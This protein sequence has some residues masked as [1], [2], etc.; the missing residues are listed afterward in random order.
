[1]RQKELKY[2]G[3]PQQGRLNADDSPFA[4][5]PNE[6][7]NAENVR[8]GSTDK[9][10]TGVVESVGGNVPLTFGYVNIGGQKWMT[11]NLNVAHF[12]NGDEIP[13][14][15]DPVEWAA[16][17]YAACCFYDNDPRNQNEY[18]KLYNW[19][20]VNDPR[21][22]APDGW[23]VPSQLDFNYLINTLGTDAG[24][25][26]KTTGFEF[27][28]DPN[29]GA[30]NQSQLSM[31]GHGYRDFDGTYAGLG[32]YGDFWT[33][34]EDSSTDAFECYLT[35]DS[36]DFD[37]SGSYTKTAGF[38]VRLIYDSNRYITIGAV[39]D[40]ENER[41][42]YF[43]YDTDPER[44]DQVMC[45][46]TN[47][48]TIYKIID[49]S[50]VV[51]GLN[52]SKNSL[53]HSARITDDL[54]S[55][56]DGTNNEPR[57]LNI[58]S[59][60][61]GNNSLFETDARPYIF[62][63]NF[64]EITMIKP[65]PIYCPNIQKLVDP[66]YINNFIATRSFEFAFM[67]QYYDNEKSVVGSY[68]IAS[69]LDIQDGASNYIQVDMDGNENIPYTVRK[70]FLIVRVTDG[71][72]GGGNTAFV[73]RTWDREIIEDSLAIDDQNN[74]ISVLTN[75]FYNEIVGE[76]LAP[77]DV[78]R[79]YDLVPI[80]SQTHEI[81]KQR[82]FLGNNINGYDT[83]T[84]TSLSVEANNN[85]TNAS[86]QSFQLYKLTIQST[87]NIAA[88]KQWAFKGYLIFDGM[89]YWLFKTAGSYAYTLG[90]NTLPADPTQPPS[91][92]VINAVGNL[93]ELGYTLFTIVNKL[94]PRVTNNTVPL[95][96]PVTEDGTSYTITRT[97]ALVQ[98][99]AFVIIN[100]LLTSGYNV[101]AQ[102]S[103]YKF[104]VVFYDY[105]MRK[106]GVIGNVK[107]D[108]LNQVYEYTSVTGEPSLISSISPD[109]IY[110]PLANLNIVQA[111]DTLVISDAD[112]SLD[113]TY[114]V[115][116]VLSG[117]TGFRVT[118]SVPTISTAIS[119]VT[120][121]VYRQLRV[122]ITTPTAQNNFG[123][124]NNIRWQLSNFNRTLEIPDWAYYYSVV[125]TLNL[126]TR[127]F[128][129]SYTSAARYFTKDILG[130]WNETN[131]VPGIAPQGA[132]AIG[133]PIDNL[134]RNGLG[135]TYEPE[136]EDICILSTNSINGPTT[137][138]LP[139]VG[140]I[141]NYILV[142]FLDLGDS[143]SGVGSGI[144]GMNIRY[145]V[146]HPYK[147]VEQEPYY[148]V[149]EIY[150]INNPKTIDRE[151]STLSG[152]L[153]GDCA[154]ITRYIASGAGTFNTTFTAVGM[155]A[156]D[157]YYQRWDNDGGKI[158]VITN[159]G[160]TL[161]PTAVS[162][163]DAIISGSSINGTSTFRANDVNYVPSDCGSITKLQL[164]SKIQNEGT[165]ML[166]LC[167]SEI[168][169]MYLGEQQIIDS[170]GGT[171]F[172]GAS[173]NV[174]STINTLKGNYGCINP[175]SVVQY[176]GR[177][178]FFDASN[179]RVLQYSENGIDP[180]S[181]I[182]M[183]RFW[184]NWAA[185]YL[186]M[187]IE[188][189][190][191]YGDRPY[192]FAIVDPFHDEL[193]M[194]IPTLTDESPKGYLPDYPNTIYPF[195]ILDYQGK[196]I[197]YN[198]GLMANINPHWQGS[199]MFNTDY[200]GSVQNKVLSFRH[201]LPYLH[202]Q[203]NQNTFYDTYSP[204]KIMFTSNSIPQVPKV[205]D[206]FLSESN[207]IPNFVYFYNNNPFL[208]TSDLGEI[209]F[210]NVEGVW[211]SNIFRNKIVPTS[212]GYDTN[213]LLT[214]EVMRNRNMYIMAQFLPTSTP[215][216]LRIVQIAY[217][218]SKGHNF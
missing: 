49:S 96:L 42:V 67:Y 124:V 53:I 61:V 121:K 20:A 174:I 203:D 156:N 110:T 98:P 108:E 185:K 74:G 8:T 35:Y 157:L 34:N 142:K 138:N 21:G 168:T 58:N 204:S 145:E 100:N 102:Q 47:T 62:P 210:R 188:D 22:L 12:K 68:S 205:Y 152:N 103:P 91:G 214:A 64:P 51:G 148:E 5:N 209:C 79:P 41:L 81:A 132:A 36:A 45:L 133:L 19:Y 65:P 106:C 172:F 154:Q 43:N 197:T 117:L 120:I 176:R 200:F 201:G 83:P 84:I 151:Y 111:G 217:S 165:V 139:V 196:T 99:T 170:T 39:D 26:A 28:I 147:P 178:Y 125:R 115:T 216:E 104:G 193:L 32:E 1:M 57:K 69:R 173:S 199:F 149:G 94:L 17:D 183:S 87:N 52:F 213:G 211:Y 136:N 187:T 162:F 208:Q 90:S 155:C 144:N 59:A 18:G 113:G 182:K 164:T 150:P 191:S 109:L 163:S 50:Q 23:R 127:Y 75:N 206:N 105:A 80:Y 54:L 184:N 218:I 128:I 86:S 146:Y 89:D 97:I 46:Y 179:G 192:I 101:Y 129:Q 11:Q 123:Y 73:A 167:T 92:V 175:E 82:Y 166:G 153:R 131:P 70:V 161:N 2:F 95:P 14:I 177:V 31:K 71:S 16:A 10:Y 63:L 7:I 24:G 25:K 60:I 141:G 122:E 55:W 6:W 195:D 140:A 112:P 30:T 3:D 118:P 33:S 181:S 135:Y 130:A 9:G 137:A 93:V 107:D 13:V 126:R 27:W 40:V 4:V 171:K 169:S 85:S 29:T 66:T 189:I 15:T 207:L 76:S 119:G 77:D 186:S 37:N 180:I 44:N 116:R 202:N 158:N 134:L 212:T 72:T 48:N 194:S 215:L 56:V 159:Y 198:I 78:I 160:R 190:E 143:P 38:A 114:E 88:S